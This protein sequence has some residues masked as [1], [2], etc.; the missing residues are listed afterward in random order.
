[1]LY[2]DYNREE[3]ALCSHLFRLLHE[4]LVTDCYNSPLARVLQFL[5]IQGSQ[6]SYHGVKIFAEVAL[7]RDA[8]FARK[9]NVREFMDKVVARIASQEGITEYKRYSELPSPLNDPDETHPKKIG[10]QAKKL[11]TGLTKAELTIYGCLQG[12]FN[13]KPDLAITI[14][15][16]LIVYEAKFT[17]PFNAA[18]LDRTKKIADVWA[19]E[20]FEDLGFDEKP[21]VVVST[22]G[23]KASKPEPDLDWETVFEIQKDFYP[24]N[25][26]TYIAF[27]SASR[28]L[29]SFKW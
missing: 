14:D 7:I 1:M 3:R 13:A 11:S 19:N 28:L 29:Q 25:D 20:L 23:A 10:Y 15:N 16:K 12:M 18:Q 4:K 26:R 5:P 9:P 6:F 2:D 22:I 17:A 24:A 8:Y 21:Q 27:E